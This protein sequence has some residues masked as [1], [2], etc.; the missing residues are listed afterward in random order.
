MAL[1]F[2]WS[3]AKRRFLLSSGDIGWPYTFPRPWS[4]WT[5]GV[6]TRRECS[7]ETLPELTV[8]EATETSDEDMVGGVVRKK[9]GLKCW[10]GWEVKRKGGEKWRKKLFSE[11]S[12]RS[13]FGL[14]FDFGW[15]KEG[16]V[17]AG[18]YFY[19]VGTS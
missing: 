15:R 8:E 2:C 1:T 13:F 12:L 6:N 3:S 14:L 17:I 11:I 16:L 19:A 7:G 9:P 10:K 5:W 4:G 18:G